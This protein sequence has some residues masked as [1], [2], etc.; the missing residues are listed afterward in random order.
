MEITR[1]TTTKRN[2]RALFALGFVLSSLAAVGGA[3]ILALAYSR[4][5]T[6]TQPLWQFGQYVMLV[7][8]ANLFVYACLFFQVRKLTTQVADFAASQ[9]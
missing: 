5:P 1:T 9:G 7:G 2:L 4:A 8:L 6:A 3:L